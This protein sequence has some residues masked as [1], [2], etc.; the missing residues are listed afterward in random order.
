[1]W[2]SKSTVALV[3]AATATPATPQSGLDRIE[4]FGPAL[5][6]SHDQNGIQRQS[7]LYNI[8]VLGLIYLSV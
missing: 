5:A 3:D 4:E 6:P 8:G 2:C 7:L 1:M